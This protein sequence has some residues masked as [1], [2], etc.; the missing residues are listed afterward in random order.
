V[1]GKSVATLSVS[2]MRSKL[3][4]VSWDTSARGLVLEFDAAL[5][6]R[7]KGLTESFD[8]VAQQTRTFPLQ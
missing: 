7:A 3:P 4:F 2:L 8:G 1:K 5:S 6:V